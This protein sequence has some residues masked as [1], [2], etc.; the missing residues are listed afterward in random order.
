MV[1]YIIKRI[2]WSVPVM[3]CVV[4]IV[5]SINFIIPGN[6]ALPMR[7]V[8][9]L[10]LNKPYIVQLGNYIWR[11]ITRLDLGKSYLSNMNITAEL[12]LKLP[13]TCLLSLYSIGLMLVIGLPA[14]ILSAIK[15]YS[16]LDA[17]FTALALILASIPGFVMA[18]L[19][20]LFFGVMLRWLPVTGLET[21]SSWILPVFCT[22]M[23]GVAEF[24]RMTRTT[25]L[26]VIRQDYIRTAKSKGM[27]NLDIIRKHALKNCLIPLTTVAGRF[28]ATMF[29]GSLIVEII[30]NL[31]GMG[32]YVLSALNSR[33]YAVINGSVVVISLYIC[34]INIVVDI[35]Y[36]FIDPR[37]KDSFVSAKRT[38]AAMQETP[39]TTLIS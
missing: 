35:L 38:Q 27:K 16:A 14:G 10:G 37:I 2:L 19:S 20:A 26:E 18:L 29:S 11:I 30:F 21:G 4:I 23:V 24:M 28:V 34:I 39:L 7:R 17:S 15:Q 12:A 31:P 33:D 22:A 3:L 5:F 6:P 8:V 13:V 36:V 25:M 9:E 32:S 1:K